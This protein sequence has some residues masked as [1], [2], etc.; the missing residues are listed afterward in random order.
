METE[1]VTLPAAY[2]FRT[3]STRFGLFPTALKLDE[4]PYGPISTT[5]QSSRYNGTCFLHSSTCQQIF[6]L[7]ATTLKPPQPNF[8]A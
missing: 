1:S 5:L 7:F 4:L 6:F 2:R 3:I 8:L